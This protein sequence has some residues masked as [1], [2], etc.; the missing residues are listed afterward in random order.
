M[1]NPDLDNA[2]PESW[3]C[4]NEYGSPNAANNEEL[5]IEDIDSNSIILYPNPVKDRLYISGNS[6]SY[7]IELFSLLG[8][9]VMTFSNV[10]EIDVTILNKGVYLI[11]I[12]N[13]TSMT[14]KRMVKF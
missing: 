5:S 12:S 3:D 4:I 6:E 10:N 9:R 2:L 8:Q 7:D 14:V 1:I 13:E 11:R